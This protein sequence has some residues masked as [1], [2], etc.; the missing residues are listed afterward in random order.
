MTR[1]KASIGYSKGKPFINLSINGR[2]YRFWNGSAIGSNRIVGD[3]PTLLL[4]LFED[5]L[6]QGWIP[7]STRTIPRTKKKPRLIRNLIQER[8]DFITCNDYSTLYKRDC[9]FILKEWLRFESIKDVRYT[10]VSLRRNNLEEFI[11]KKNLSSKSHSNRRS[12]LS[13]L[14]YELKENPIK[15]IKIRRA[16]SVLH[17]PIKDVSGLLSDIEV[18]SANLHLTCLLMYGCLLRPH[19]EI[20]LLTWNDINIQKHLISLSGGQNKSGRNRVVPIPEFVRGMLYS[21]LTNIRSTNLLSGSE[22]AFNS[23]YIKTLWTRYKSQSKLLTEG[24]TLYSLRHTAAIK[25]YE[26]SRS[27]FTVQKVMGHADVTTTLNYL[28]GLEIESVDLNELP[29]L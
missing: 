12:I 16:K 9:R 21:R 7:N 25:V 14:L 2:R 19:Q 4:S 11:F 20:R 3:N 26:K 13:A 27:V 23:D 18:Y 28:R 10:T 15:E 8:L 24:Q 22:K 5:K 1:V 6:D 29:E 17:R